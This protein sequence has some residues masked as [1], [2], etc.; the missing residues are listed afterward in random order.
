MKVYGHIDQNVMFMDTTLQIGLRNYE[1][2]LTLDNSII[3][4]QEEGNE[5]GLQ[6][7][8]NYPSAN[9]GFAATR[10]EMFRFIHDKKQAEIDSLIN[11]L[12]RNKVTFSTTIHLMAE[13]FGLTYYA[14]NIDTTLT[15]VQ[16]ERCRRNFGILMAYGKE[17]FEKGV[18]LRIGTDC[19]NGGK[20]I[21]SEQLLLY[22]YGF[23]VSAILQISTINGARA[24]GID[25]KYGS[26][27]KG[28]KANLIIFEE[29]PFDN[30]RNFLS[31]KTVI[32]DGVVFKN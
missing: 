23:P 2:L 20:A 19:P 24:L 18:K 3:N 26:I 14:D 31:K 4:F 21:Q 11:K 6:I 25:D 10:L 16:L 13:Q 30:Y 32:K 7:Q 12:A 9:P 27:E 15:N 1:H 28:K 8:K 29:N 5:F 17:L 22:E